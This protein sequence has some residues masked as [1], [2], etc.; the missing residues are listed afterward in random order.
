M[1]ASSSAERICMTEKSYTDAVFPDIAERY[2]TI[3]ENIELSKQ[4]AQRKDDVI[5]MAVTKTVP[6]ERVNYAVSLGINVLG[7][8]RVQEFLEKSDKYS[9]KC[10]IHFIGGLQNNKVK[11]IIDR[12][13]MIHSLDSLKLAAEIQRRASALSVVSDVLIEVN[14]AEEY[15]KGG[16]TLSQLDDF[17][18]ALCEYENIRLRGLMAIPPVDIN[19][20]N[21]RYFAQMREVFEKMKSADK[22]IDTL[23]MGMSGDY[24]SAIKHGSTLIRIGSGLFGARNYSQ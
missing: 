23:S 14:I 12:V 8:N 16:V 18:K 10:E 21:E 22:N 4:T 3:R 19:G 20:T 17:S 6:A 2:E 15:T 11:Y 24:Q 13:K 7:E 1:T 9:K 5:L